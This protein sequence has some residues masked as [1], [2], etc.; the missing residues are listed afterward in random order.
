MLRTSKGARRYNEPVTL[1][2]IKATADSYGHAEMG[3]PVEVLK[4]YAYVRQMSEQKA[5]MTFQQAD[6]IGLE[7]EMRIPVVKFNA[8]R[9]RGHIVHFAAPQEID[10]RGRIMRFNGYYQQDDPSYE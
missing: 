6:A 2:M 8:L 1:L 4:T 5:M 10:M 7:I 9:W 3:E